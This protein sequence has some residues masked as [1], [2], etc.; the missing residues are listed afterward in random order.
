MHT[1]A[2]MCKMSMSTCKMCKTSVSMC[3]MS[4]STCKMCKMSVSMCEM[5]AIWFKVSM[6]N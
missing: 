2:L 6:I 1:S 4:V 3:E 5:L